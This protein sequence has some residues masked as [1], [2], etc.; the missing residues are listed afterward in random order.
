MV[1]AIFAI[2]LLGFFVWGHHMFISGMSPYSTSI[3]FS[4]LTLSIGVPS[5]IKTFNWLGTLWG[6]RIR[7]TT[8]M[9]FAHRLRFAVRRRRHHRF[10]AWPDVARHPLHDTYFVAGHFHL[11]MGVA[12][13]F[14]MFAAIYFWFPKMFGRM[15]NE[16]LGRFTSG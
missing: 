12:S 15:M 10:G 11:V 14:G 8:P 1:F 2:G 7:F 4:I 3:A 13:I 16:R 6:A 5:A 9:L